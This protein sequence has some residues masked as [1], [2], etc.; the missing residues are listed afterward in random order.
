MMRR[1]APL[2]AVGS[3]AAASALLGEARSASVACAASATPVYRFSGIRFDEQPYGA[4]VHIDIL[5]RSCAPK[6]IGVWNVSFTTTNNIKP[7][8][9]GTTTIQV[10]V[11][12]LGRPAFDSTGRF[13]LTTLPGPRVRVTLHALGEHT[14]TAAVTVKQA[15]CKCPTLPK[16]KRLNRSPSKAILDYIRN[17]E[18][19]RSKPYDD[20]GPGKG[21]CTVGYGHVL[22]NSPCT[23]SEKSVTKSEAEKQFEGDVG[24]AQADL[25]KYAHVD[26][27][28]NQY[29]AM[30]DFAFNAGIKGRNALLNALNSCD[31]AAL[32]A[33]MRI[34]V[35]SKGQTLPSLAARREYEI[36]LYQK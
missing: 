24:A 25:A 8:N 32:F 29:D 9:T 14:A 30:L 4:Y 2:L 33:Q 23:G 34:Y 18:Q 21:A 3:L 28:Q 6:G 22:H 10:V 36:A 13:S 15:S 31:D 11:A 26:L 5:G 17:Q 1:L 27:D 19:F 7:S 12:K 20:L 16:G 35:T